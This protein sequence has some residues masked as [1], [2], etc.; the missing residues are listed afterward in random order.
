MQGETADPLAERVHRAIAAQVQRAHAGRH[1]DRAL[2]E[3]EQAD[4]P[5]QRIATRPQ[6]LS[7]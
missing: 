4:E 3:L 6:A 1:Q 2:D 7:P 5:Q